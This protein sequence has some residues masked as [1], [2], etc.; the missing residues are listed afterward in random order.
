MIVVASDDAGPSSETS[1]TS[2]D[3]TE[4]VDRYPKMGVIKQSGRGH[5][6][7]FRAQA[8]RSA[9]TSAPPL[10]NIFLRPCKCTVEHAPRYPKWHIS[11]V[12]SIQVKVI[13]IATP[14][15]HYSY[16]PTLPVV[17]EAM[18][19]LVIPAEFLAITR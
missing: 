17:K 7:I 2:T 4:P 15:D 3:A 6:K 1:I 14:C 11:C 12:A 9:H 5:Q 8:R 13:A 16:S 18:A 19:L 10:E